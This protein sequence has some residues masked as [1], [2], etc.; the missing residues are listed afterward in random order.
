MFEDLRPHLVEL[1]KRLDGEMDIDAGKIKKG[2][3]K[4]GYFDQNRKMLDDET[5]TLLLLARSVNSSRYFI[6]V[7]KASTW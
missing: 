7:M 2:D 3:I 4:I 6:I 1:R 5:E